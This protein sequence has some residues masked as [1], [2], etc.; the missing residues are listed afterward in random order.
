MQLV[1]QGK[2]A[3]DDA[4]QVGGLCPE[5][6]EVKV[7]QEDGS[8]VEKYRPITLRMLLT[9]TGEHTPFP[10]ALSAAVGLTSRRSW[11]WVLVLEPQVGE[12]PAARMWREHELR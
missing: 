3:L 4:N 11:F 6:R 10:S 8:L 7:I 12:V 2:L 1:E 9:H 5:L